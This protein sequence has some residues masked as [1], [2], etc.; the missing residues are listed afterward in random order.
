MRL[1]ALFLLALI[2]SIECQTAVNIDPIV[3]TVGGQLVSYS[4]A[5]T[6]P[7]GIINPVM[8]YIEFDDNSSQDNINICLNSFQYSSA[9]TSGANL[10]STCPQGG[11]TTV[12]S[13][14]TTAP[15]SSKLKFARK[16]NS[17][18]NT[19]MKMVEDTTNPAGAAFAI[20][21][22]AAGI[23]VTAPSLTTELGYTITFGA[24]A[25]DANQYYYN[26]ACAAVG[27]LKLNEGA[28]F[29]VEASSWYY[30]QFNTGAFDSTV[31]NQINIVTNGTFYLQEDYLPTESWNMGSPLVLN[32]PA[33]MANGQLYFIG[34]FN[35][36]TTAA[37]YSIN[38]TTAGCANTNT[39]G[40]GCYVTA[41]ST[42]SETGITPLNA[43]LGPNNNGAAQEFSLSDSENEYIYFSLTDL[44]DYDTP[45]YVRVSVGNNQIDDN[46]VYAPNIYAK[47]GGYPSSE[48][49]DAAVTS[50]G[51]ANQLVLT[52]NDITTDEW[53]IAVQ[54]PADFSIWVGTNCAGNCSNNDHGSCMC[55]SGNTT[56]DCSTL[57]TNATTYRDVFY[58][59]PSA[60]GDSA[61]VCDCSDDD[62]SDSFDC[63]QKSSPTV[64]FIILIVIGGL[65]ILFV[66]IGVPLY[67]YISNKRK[68]RYERI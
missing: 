47:N 24:Y 68:E 23:I 30:Y 37:T 6:I 48:S 49:S 63:S 16:S 55:S 11:F 5:F 66:A 14:V 19:L 61:G 57:A 2:Y 29:Q 8:M 43:T 52:I 60:T 50:N 41:N 15:Q 31:N 26:D 58:S 12:T 27:T 51:V 62:Y 13:N 33:T 36:G 3:G 7:Q 54:L 28:T 10:Q 4:D 44:P 20:P 67:C 46:D 9:A 25:C 18:G 53:Y 32:T 35:S 45:Y 42:A 39:F 1:L 40:P 34:F 65:I 64:L 21:S 38:V 22:T 56:V 17:F 59:L